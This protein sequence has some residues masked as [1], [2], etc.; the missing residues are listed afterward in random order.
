MGE[1]LELDRRIRKASVERCWPGELGAI[2]LGGRY[3]NLTR[4]A[5]DGG[6]TMREPKREVIGNVGEKTVK[7]SALAAF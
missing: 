1:P 5:G 2:S 6:K 4:G 3:Y 7:W